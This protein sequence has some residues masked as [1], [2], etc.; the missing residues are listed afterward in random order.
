MRRYIQ[1]GLL[2]G[3]LLALIAVPALAN[4]PP[5]P[6]RV[7][8]TTTVFADLIANVGGD[9]VTVT[10]ILP[11]GGDPHSYDPTP[12]EVRAVAAADLFFFNGLGL[13]SWVDRVIESAARRDLVR[14]ELSEGL[15]PLPG[16]SFSAHDHETGDPHFWVDIDHALHYVQR[17]EQALSRLDP[18]GAAFYAQRSQAYRAE[19][20]ALHVWFQEQIASIVPEHRQLVTYHDGFAYLARAYGLDM[21]GFLVRNPDREP[22]PQELARLVRQI[23]SLGV[24]AIFAEPQINPRFAQSLASEAGVRVGFLYSDS[25]TPDVPTYIDMMRHNALELVRLLR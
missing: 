2:L 6:L 22:S 12:R 17:I 24:R 5:S 3:T 25:L 4:S 16:V 1:L 21:V 9:R 10:S 23:Q 18:Q 20:E 19:L 13:E 14:V 15:T 8:T 7:V 11:Y